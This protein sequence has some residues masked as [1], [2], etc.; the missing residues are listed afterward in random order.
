MKIPYRYRRMLSH[1]G[2][3]LMVL[4]L[5]FAIT[6]LCWVVW[7]ERY[8]VYTRDGAV[9][10]LEVSSNTL[11]GEVATPPVAD[12]S[13]VSIYYNEGADAIETSNA[14]TQLNGYY[15]S[16]DALTTDIAG[17]WEALDHL[18]SG[19]PI[20]IDLK[21][22][23]GSF[24]YGSNLPGAIASASVSTASVDEIIKDMRD[25]G[26]Y[27][28]ARISAF[29]DY[30]YGRKNVANGL[31]HINRKGLWPD[32]GGCYWLNPTEP[33]VL[34]WVS[35]MVN[36][37]KGLGFNEVVL[38]DFRFPAGESYIFNGDK[39][40]AIQ[41]AAA[42]IYSNCAD[43]NF[44]LSFSV[45]TPNFTLPQ[46]RTRMYLEGVSAENVGSRI[47]MLNLEEPQIRLVFVAQTNDTRYDE[48]GVLRPI[49]SAEQLEAQKIATGSR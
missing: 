28:I 17:S 5:I 30:E 19:I 7:L 43:P 26:F 4:L 27:T 21:G 15:I 32:E 37:L 10:D 12:T 29:R 24:Y 33:A 9:L 39:D 11:T 2:M 22:G 20:M 49:D 48:Y 42:T 25:K 23:Y 1:L 40:A 8:I 35:S 46:G 34:N 36:E 41:Q 6:W 45:A 13:R 38:A 47:A 31:M 18:S 3:V 14:L 16:A 44:T